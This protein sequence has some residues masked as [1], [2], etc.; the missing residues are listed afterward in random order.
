MLKIFAALLVSACAEQSNNLFAAPCCFCDLSG[1]WNRLLGSNREGFNVRESVELRKS[2]EA[3]TVE[4]YIASMKVENLARRLRGSSVIKIEE[5]PDRK[6]KDAPFE[7]ERLKI[8]ETFVG[9]SELYPRIEITSY[10]NRSI[11][12][13]TENRGKKNTFYG[14]LTHG[15]THIDWTN[16][17]EAW[18]QRPHCTP[19][20][21][22]AVASPVKTVAGTKEKVC[23]ISGDWTGVV[24]GKG[25]KLLPSLTISV[26]QQGDEFFASASGLWDKAMGVLSADGLLTISIPL[27]GLQ[28]KFQGLIDNDCKSIRWIGIGDDNDNSK[29][30]IWCKRGFCH[31]AINNHLPMLPYHGPPAP[32]QA[33]SESQVA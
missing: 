17:A 27:D 16:R 25:K 28:H 21:N 9:Q 11:T 2:E 15:C 12:L 32:A 3:S 26:H 13:K 6:P 14:R 20:L 33:M 24:G 1:N 18:C 22:L 29:A 30:I 5:Q 10:R 8:S 23:D 31:P 7:S 19:R 4:E